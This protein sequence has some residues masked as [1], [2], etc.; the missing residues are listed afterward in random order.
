MA[1][2]LPTI[3][4]VVFTIIEPISLVAG[5]LGAIVDPAWFVAEQVPQTK[6]IITENSI[7]LALELGNL[8]LLLAFIGLSVLNTTSEIKVVRSYLVALWLG[9]I[10]HILFSGYGL[11]KDKLLS[12]AEWNAMAWGNVAMTLFLLIMRSAYFL[13]LF[14]PDR[15]N[16]AS[17]AKKTT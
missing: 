9:D 8:Y 2:S 10:G 16:A 4:R 5:F 14:G 12:P 17:A 13:G 7:V 15:A 6:P 11:G 1:S 3:P